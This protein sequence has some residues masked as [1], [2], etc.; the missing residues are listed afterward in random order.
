MIGSM[1]VSPRDDDLSTPASPYSAMADAGSPAT[2]TDATTNSGAA[3]YTGP[4]GFAASNTQ[5]QHAALPAPADQQ[6]PY[7]TAPH[8]FEATLPEKE[9]DEA[10]MRKPLI[11]NM[12]RRCGCC[13]HAKDFNASLVLTAV[14]FVPFA[15]FVTSV[16][17]D[18]VWWP[19]IPAVVLFALTEAMLFCAVSLDPGIVP[20]ASATKDLA[21][22]GD[23]RKIVVDTIEFRQEVCR[24]CRVW[25]PPRSGHCAHCDNCV[26]DYDHHCGVLG[27]CVGERTFRFFAMFTQCVAL[28]CAFVV[29]CCLYFLATM[30]FD[31]EGAT[32][33]GRWRIAASFGVTLY[34]GCGGCF[35]FP[36]A[37]YYTHLSCTGR[38]QKDTLGRRTESA[39]I[40]D[41]RA[42][43][44]LPEF[45]C[46][47]CGPMP[48][49]E[50]DAYTV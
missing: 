23:S 13:L 30:D 25:R 29:G 33:R 21:K 35:A 5:Q 22:P 36:Q 8:P 50:I 37:G 27:S 6:F 24:T 40:A 43:C 45:C 20:P 3:P 31:T 49:S 14:I 39:Q 1:F 18:G 32:D 28:L 15:V 19:V 44:C 41:H 11:G 38:T 26:R 34:A 48:K 4:T 12:R 7:Q 46:R 9:A 10:A 2:R 42:R 16:P 17:P 47:L